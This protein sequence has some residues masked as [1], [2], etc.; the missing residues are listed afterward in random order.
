MVCTPFLDEITRYRSNCPNRG[1]EE[2]RNRNSTKLTDFNELLSTGENIAVTHST[3]LNAT[4]QT[5]ESIKQWGYTLILD[6]A[7]D[8]ISQFNETSLVQNDPKQF[9]G[10]QD[11][12]ILFDQNLITVDDSTKKV[13][14]VGNKCYDSKFDA[15]ERMAEAGRLYLLQGTLLVC[16][17]PPEMFSS[18]KQVYILTYMFESYIMKPYFEIHNIE[19]VKQSITQEDGKY[20]LCPYSDK[21]DIEFKNKIRPLI[22]LID[23]PK[24]NFNVNF[25]KNWFDNRMK[26]KDVKELKAHIE[27]VVKSIAKVTANREEIMWTCPKDYKSKLEGRRYTKAT[28]ITPQ[29]EEHRLLIEKSKPDK[30]EYESHLSCFVPSN[31]KGTNK[32]RFR[33]MLAYCTDIYY[34]PI[35]SNYFMADNE[36]RRKAG[37]PEIKLEGDLF[38]LSCLI[39]WVWRSQIRDGKPITLYLPSKHSREIFTKWLNNEL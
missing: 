21:L 36:N 15:I 28:T 29:C 24:L 27:Y 16:I 38:G 33:K 8:P 13:N 19:Y 11:I 18:F 39:Q 14:W 6:E 7:L 20:A 31:C 9:M 32:Y 10:P 30:K 22:S 23:S 4:A 12:K 25:S 2:P 37:L 3:F 1:L 5:L 35:I 26:D 34:N 17:F